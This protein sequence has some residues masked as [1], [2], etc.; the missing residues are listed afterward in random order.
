MKDVSRMFW[1]VSCR[2]CACDA[3][4]AARTITACAPG[5]SSEE[6]ILCVAGNAATRSGVCGCL[7]AR[8]RAALCK[9][10]RS[11]VRITARR[12][13]RG[14]GPRC[15]RCRRYRA[16][17]AR[18]CAARAPSRSRAAIASCAS[19]WPRNSSISAPHQICPIGLAMPLAGD[20]GRRAVHRLEQRRKLARRVQVR[21]RRDADRAGARRAEVAQDV[22]E[23]VA[24][25]DDVEE[26]AA[27]ARNAR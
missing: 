27:A 5:V 12:R 22:A 20:V 24:R 10:A 25:D 9:A 15:S 7:G 8:R 6:A 14:R 21:A 2:G 11:D 3:A 18:R 19:R 16:C 26:S 4:H 23:Q 13:S 1:M 17:A